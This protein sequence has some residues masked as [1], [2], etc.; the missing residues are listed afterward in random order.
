MKKTI[1]MM[2]ACM[3]C[4]ACVSE[5]F[6]AEGTGSYQTT[7]V[8]FPRLTVHIPMTDQDD[9]DTAVD[10]RKNTASGPAAGYSIISGDQM[11]SADDE[12]YDYTVKSVV[13]PGKLSLSASAISMADAFSEADE[14]KHLKSE[15]V[16]DAGNHLAIFPSLYV[17]QAPEELPDPTDGYRY[18]YLGFGN[19]SQFFATYLYKDQID[20][21]NEPE[22][23]YIDAENGQ[24]Y[25]LGQS[26]PSKPGSYRIEGLYLNGKQVEPTSNH[27]IA[28]YDSIQ[29]FVM[30]DTVTGAIST[31]YCADQKT[32]A[33]PNFSYNLVGLEDAG[34]YT[35]EHAAMI[36][37]VA[38]NAYWGRIDDPATAEKEF[39]SLEAMREMMRNALDENGQRIFSEEEVG[40]LDDGVAT[41]LTQFAIWHF[42]NAMANMEFV[43]VHYIKK[44][45]EFVTNHVDYRALSD[46][47]EETLPKVSLLF[48]LYD[49]LIHLPPTPITQNTTANTVINTGNFLQDMTITLVNK[50]NDPK[51]QD[52][53]PTNDVYLADISFKL[54]F[55]TVQ[56]SKDYLGFKI[57]D[58]SGEPLAEC[59]ISGDPQN[60]EPFLTATGDT[61]TLKNVPL[62]EGE[63]NLTFELKGAQTL[64][65]GVYLY[66][67]EVAENPE[68]PDDPTSQ[69]MVGVAEGERSVNV[70]MLASLNLDVD[71]EV[72]SIKR[73]WR[74][75]PEVPPMDVP[76]TGDTMAFW[77][78]PL[79]ISAVGMIVLN[80]TRKKA[81]QK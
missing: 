7:E 22:P 10:E 37:T 12:E 24:K 5:C 13:T 65:H 67:S 30:L 55:K 74:S 72:Y 6:A 73:F 32:S 66:L 71:D 81:V 25:W 50:A 48:K 70:S 54:G 45:A 79:L 47:P 20:P 35:E 15:V 1:C 19:T 56:G 63:C 18:M 59:C 8:S 41:T 62:T 3:M 42:S 68:D 27:Y 76:E 9:P 78:F 58:T 75:Q 39:G 77:F 46:V 26:H 53:D 14:M 43:N 2:L 52:A 69:T 36:R 21:E 80:V 17:T 4:I 60:G 33:K 16:P 40:L 64:D 61:Y 29:H 34:H 23:I 31:T 49:Y 44:N 28:V 51:N 57:L 11:T 38:N